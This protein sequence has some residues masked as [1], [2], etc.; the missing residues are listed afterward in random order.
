VE[1]EPSV[2]VHAGAP[3]RLA[4]EQW[5][6]STLDSHQASG[7]AR[8]QWTEM[9]MAMLPMGGLISAVRMPAHLVHA[10]AQS[11]EHATVDA[12]LAAVLGGGP[13]ICCLHGG[14]RYYALV[15]GDMPTTWRGTVEG[16]Q[17]LGVDCLGRDAYLGVPPVTR[18]AYDPGTWASYWSVPAASAGALCSPAAVARLIADGRQTLTAPSEAD[19]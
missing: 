18:L 15:P 4:V 3:Q 16:W 19:A 5:L 13:V 17:D 6:L 11:D 1:P 10:L 2:L 7:W 8:V 14:H 12:F 9:G